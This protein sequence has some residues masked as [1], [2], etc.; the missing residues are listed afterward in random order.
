LKRVRGF[1]DL[2]GI[3]LRTWSISAG[4]PL[5]KMAASGLGL[6]EIEKVTKRLANMP[7]RNWS[8]SRGIIAPDNI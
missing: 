6:V 5:V 1:A 3:F 7:I 4:E 8:M 2:A